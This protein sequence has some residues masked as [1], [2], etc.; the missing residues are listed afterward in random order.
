MLLVVER[1]SGDCGAGDEALGQ[2]G[3]VGVVINR[4][5]ARAQHGYGRGR[6]RAG[7][8]Q[9]GII[10]ADSGLEQHFPRGTIRGGKC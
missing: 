6:N 10:R 3:F 5:W 9:R 7:D 1:G 4:C 2:G 8:G